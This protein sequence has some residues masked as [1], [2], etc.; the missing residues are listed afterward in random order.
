MA[1]TLLVYATTDGHTRKISQRLQEVM[2][3]GGDAVTVLPIG[4]A[5]SIDLT[6]YEKIVIGASIRYGKHA[7]EVTDFIARNLEQLRSRPSAFFSVNLVA[8]KPEKDQP[9]TNPY[10]RRFLR[11]IPWKPVYVAVFAGRLDYPRYTPLD[12]WIIRMIMWITR[13]PTDPT[14]I[15]EFTDWAKVDAF[16]RRLAVLTT[17]AERGG[18]Q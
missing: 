15:V 4:E 14:A 10:V 5:Q 6:G 18:I 11:K 7:R 12:R 2:E 9:D 17:R 1:N 16:G 8:R 13:G 3:A